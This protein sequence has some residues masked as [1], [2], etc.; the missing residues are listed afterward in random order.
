MALQPFVG[1]WQLLQF[2]ELHTVGMT[3]WTGDQPVGRL[4]PVHRTAQ[5]QKKRTETF[6]S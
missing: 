6:M 2:L 5:R 3:P 4:I 1:P